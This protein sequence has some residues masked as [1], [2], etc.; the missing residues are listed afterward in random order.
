MLAVDLDLLSKRVFAVEPEMRDRDDM[1][2]LG[3][4]E[5]E[6]EVACDATILTSV[7]LHSCGK[8]RFACFCNA[9][10]KSRVVN[11]GMGNAAR[12]P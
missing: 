2:I 4:G 1:R 7:T 5:T 6:I 3:V 11:A 12:I 10:R 8:L 9:F